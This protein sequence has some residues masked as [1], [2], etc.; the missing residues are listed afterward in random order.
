MKQRGERQIEKERENQLEQWENDISTVCCSFI[1]LSIF[2][3]FSFFSIKPVMNFCNVTSIKH[4]R[5]WIFNSIYN[6]TLLLQKQ[7]L[8]WCFWSQP[9][10]QSIEKDR[11]RTLMEWIEKCEK[12]GKW[13]THSSCTKQWNDK[14]FTQ[15]FEQRKRNGDKPKGKLKRS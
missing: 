3:F 7:Q 13:R 4:S 11:I 10:A 1:F 14:K 6:R 15:V 8:C 9:Q 5:K 12:G 2:F